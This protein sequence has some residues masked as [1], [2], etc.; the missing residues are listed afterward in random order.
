MEWEK[1]WALKKIH[2]HPTFR[3]E[4]DCANCGCESETIKPLSISSAFTSTTFFFL[5]RC[6]LC[7]CFYVAFLRALR[8]LENFFLSPTLTQWIRVWATVCVVVL[9]STAHYIVH[10]WAFFF[11]SRQVPMDTVLSNYKR[12]VHKISHTEFTLNHEWVYAPRISIH[13]E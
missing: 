8:W 10:P 7:V 4:S 2:A 9:V 3:T 12:T 6:F 1:E 13:I 11:L 5:F